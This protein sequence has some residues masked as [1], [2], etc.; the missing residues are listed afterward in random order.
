MDPVPGAV[1]ALVDAYADWLKRNTVAEQMPGGW[2]EVATPF[3]DRHND[4][5]AVYVK[6]D[7][8]RIIISDDGFII[9]DMELS[10]VP[11]RERMADIEGLL[12]GYGVGVADGRELRVAATARDCPARLHLLLHA[13]MAASQLFT[14]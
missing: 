6:Q 12:R 5:L 3:M 7:G 2:T 8:D 1:A 4:A 11:T 14:K 10:G 13:M 9:G